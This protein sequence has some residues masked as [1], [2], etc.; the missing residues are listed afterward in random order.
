MLT[1]PPETRVFPTQPLREHCQIQTRSQQTAAAAAAASKTSRTVLTMAGRRRHPN[2]GRWEDIAGYASSE[3]LQCFLESPSAAQSF[4]SRRDTTFK[5]D[6]AQGA[7]TV[8]DGPNV[9]STITSALTSTGHSRVSQVTTKSFRSSDP[10]N[11]RS[12]EVPGQPGQSL[13]LKSVAFAV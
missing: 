7:A 2:Q 3:R 8:H 4:A 10:V 13:H 5:A 9:S 6:N 1:T 11:A 12:S